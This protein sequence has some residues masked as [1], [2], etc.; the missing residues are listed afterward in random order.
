MSSMNES[1]RREQEIREWIML[2]EQQEPRSNAFRMH[3]NL[4]YDLLSRYPSG[5]DV[6]V[7][8]QDLRTQAWFEHKTVA[9]EAL[10]FANRLDRK[11]LFD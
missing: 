3:P 2:I 5:T 10:E 4:V 7:M 1:I 8:L 11:S 9:E 6:Q